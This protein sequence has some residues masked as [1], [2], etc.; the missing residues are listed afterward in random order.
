MEKRAYLLSFNRRQV[1]IIPK[2]MELCRGLVYAKNKNLFAIPRDGSY[3][4]FLA[5]K[6]CSKIIAVKELNM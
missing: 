2:A 4:I 6:R 1:K 3:N 5:I